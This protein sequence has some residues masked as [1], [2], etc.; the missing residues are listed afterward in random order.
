MANIKDLRNEIIELVETKNVVALRELAESTP[1]IDFAEACNEIDD[2]QILLFV[3]KTVPSEYTA[4]VYTELS[5]N[6]QN[7]LIEFLTDKQVLELIENTYTD[8][9]VDF[10]EDMP[11]NLVNKVLKN[12]DKQTRQDINSLLNYRQDTAGSIMA[13][14]YIRVR[15]ESTVKESLDYIKKVGED[16]VTI[17]DIFV[18]DHFRNLIG[19]IDLKTLLLSDE[20]QV[21]NDLLTTNFI[22]VN[23]YA[24]QE[25]VAHLF[26][27][28]D[29]STMAVLNNDQKMIGVIT[30]DD[31]IDVITEE[32]TEDIAKMAAVKPIEKSYRETNVVSLFKSAAPW[33]LSLIVFSVFTSLIIN[34]FEAEIAKVIV[35]SSFIPFLLD[36]AGNAGSQGA[37][38]V[39]RSLALKEYDKG[40]YK[41]IV[42]KELLVGLLLAVTVGVFTFFFINLEFIIGFV[43]VDTIGGATFAKWSADWWFA[44]LKVSAIVGTTA[45]ISTAVARLLGALLPL[46]AKLIKRDPALM[47]N[48]LLT[49]IADITTLVIYFLLIIWLF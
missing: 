45:F 11:A 29:K 46:T 15:P 8:D 24:D 33:L 17:Y 41:K 47:A 23:V 44:V 22:S 43:K 49:T 2:L 39:I 9:I 26:K 25:E 14:E 35:M 38:M 30:V 32:Q 28:Y 7:H 20:S 34:S 6:Q 5:S 21:I 42:V 40:E 19:V 4:E 18:V 12:A 36:S 37:A 3:F 16:A 31:I 27:R 13:T 48:P 1:S 10:L